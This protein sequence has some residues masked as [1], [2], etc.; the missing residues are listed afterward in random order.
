MNSRILQREALGVLERHD[1]EE[2]GYR[3]VPGL[4]QLILN[5]TAGTGE[6]EAEQ[7]PVLEPVPPDSSQP[8]KRTSQFKRRPYVR[9]V[10]RYDPC[11]YCG[12]RS[13]GSID[14]IHPHIH[15]G[16]NDWRNLTPSCQQ[17]NRDKNDLD[18]LSWLLV[19]RLSAEREKQAGQLQRCPD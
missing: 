11:A 1:S 18:L 14:H 2:P 16:A 15:G 3:T 4:T 7:V 5:I 9:R 19:S 13:W 17:C 6:L 10:M 8:R 12:E